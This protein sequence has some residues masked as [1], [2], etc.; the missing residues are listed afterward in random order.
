MGYNE[1]CRGKFKEL[2]IMTV[3]SLFIYTAALF[4]KKN[5]QL[6]LNNSDFYT[7]MRTRGGSG[8][9]VPV[10]STALFNKGPLMNCI[11]VF[12]ALPA[13]IRGL[14]SLNA[15]KSQLKMFL[16]NKEYYSIDDFF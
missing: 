12:N 16:I 2:N 9:S 11:K 7:M 6:F 14:V 3:P 10:H 13:E 5:P 1:S 15:F 4:A 8:L